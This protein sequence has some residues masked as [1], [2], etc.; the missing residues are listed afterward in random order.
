MPTVRSL[1][2]E[3]LRAALDALSLDSSVA[4]VTSAADSRF[5]D[6][7]SNAAMVL[8]KRERK[9]P[10]ELGQAIVEK[11]D[12]S[13]LAEPATLAGAGFLNFRLT[14]GFLNDAAAAQ[15]SDER[16]GLAPALR[17]E[18]I[19]ID[20][21]SPN[22]AKPMH[23][24]HIRS[25]I[26][27]DCLARVARFLGHHVVTDNHVGDWGTQFGKV[28]YGWKHLL[29][30]AALERDPIPELLRLYRDVNSLEETDET[31]RHDVREELVQL[32]R[33]DAE[34][35]AIWRH[36]VAL[37]WREFEKIYALLDVTFDERLGESFYNDRLAPLCE[38]LERDGIARISEGALCVF[39]PEIP[40]LADRPCLVRKSD[41]G[42]LYATTDL[43][44]IA[45]R[46]ERWQPDAI[47]YVTGAPQALHFQQIFEV[48]RRM[49]VTVNAQHV[50]FGSILGENRKIMKTR[51]GE[52][53]QLGDVLREAVERA[54]AII[55]EKNP[56]LPAEESEAI[57][58][59][60]GIGAV[61]YAE[62]SQHRMTDYV[63]SWDKM[64]SFQGN[65]A[66]YLQNAYVRIRSIFRKAG[67]DDI[68]HA[69]LLIAEPA[70]R[71]LAIKLLQF[72]E[73]VPLVLADFRP[74]LLANYLYELA[75]T[76][77]SFYE[78]CPVLKA[79]GGTRASRHALCGL[80]ARTLRTGL[81]LLGIH[82]PE[83]M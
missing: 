59:D 68:S 50:A 51:S 74:N 78:A 10:R 36:V 43:A 5:G 29:D 66:P 1:L 58:R 62:L 35:L 46:M 12:L 67:T 75:T 45:Y 47:W 70:E 77:H 53:V 56:E 55:A 69:E 38:K 52:N 57:A 24:G 25:T 26:I 8:A 27:G 15:L 60:V 37:S 18:T 82:C 2:E 44:T 61:K 63:F 20:F 22:V 54:R 14:A 76:F 41:G 65:T 64:L 83:R 81:D 49:G 34:S 9:N 79:D 7:Q 4:E 23:V 11:I 3:R 21:S 28:I 31:V 73:T 48:A 6:Y 80:T 33:G 42:F 17:P 30:L 13:G 32:Q 72:A 16:C 19:I 71:A 39:F 40:Q